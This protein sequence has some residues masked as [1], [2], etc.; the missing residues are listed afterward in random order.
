MTSRCI[1]PPLL[2]WV[3]SYS[4]QEEFLAFY[5][6]TPAMFDSLEA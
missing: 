3:G 1:N 6:D 2:P 5:L 4:G